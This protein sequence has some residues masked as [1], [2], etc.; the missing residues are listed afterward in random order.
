LETDKAKN[1]KPAV[2]PVTGDPLQTLSEQQVKRRVEPGKYMVTLYVG[3]TILTRTFEVK[4]ENPSGVKSV[5]P[6]K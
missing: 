2:D 6:R 3:A 4:P 1:T 5:L